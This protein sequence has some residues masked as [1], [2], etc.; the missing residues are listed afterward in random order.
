LAAPR[1]SAAPRAQEVE[2]FAQ[3]TQAPAAAS[4]AQSMVDDIERRAAEGQLRQERRR[5]SCDGVSVERVALLDG[6]RVVKLTI[7]TDD[8]TVHEGWYDEAGRLQT[9]RRSGPRRPAELTSEGEGTDE[10]APAPSLTLPSWA[11]SPA[12]LPRCGW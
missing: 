5:L 6:A 8:G 1:R 10:A 11:P 7:R 2:R 4:A 3:P 12:A 9:D